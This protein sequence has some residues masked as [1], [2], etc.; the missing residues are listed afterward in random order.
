[1][2]RAIIVIRGECA[3]RTVDGADT[4]VQVLAVDGVLRGA[5]ALARAPALHRSRVV[6]AVAVGHVLALARRSA[7]VG[8]FSIQRHRQQRRERDN[9]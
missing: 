3:V 9:K 1:M 8:P 4:L 2:R 6:A 5:L 7:A